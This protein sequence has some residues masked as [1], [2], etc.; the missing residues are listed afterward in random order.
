MKYV[1][2]VAVVWLIGVLLVW[3]RGHARFSLFDTLPF[4]GPRRFYMPPVFELAALVMI[5]YA[6]WMLF[7]P[8]DG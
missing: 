6:A 2:V 8:K 4:V 7:R 3:V 1:K 5:A